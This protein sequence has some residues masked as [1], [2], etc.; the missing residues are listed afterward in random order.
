MEK[1]GTF[2]IDEKVLIT[3]VRVAELFKRRSSAIVSAHG[4]S[5]SQ[6]NALRVLEIAPQGS[7]SITDLSRQMLVS[8]P[9]LSGIAKRLDKAGFVQRL[10]DDHDERRTLLRITA[11]GLEVL[12]RIEQRQR[13]NIREMLVPCPTGRKEEALAMLKA[14]LALDQPGPGPAADS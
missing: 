8:S 13:D 11:K 12:A 1:R 2:G 4:L 9:N 7:R 6:Y 5:F 3:V 10:R 14:I